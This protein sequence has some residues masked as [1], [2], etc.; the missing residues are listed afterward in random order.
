MDSVVIGA[1]GVQILLATGQDLTEATKLEMHVV[2]PDGSTTTW[3]ATASATP[4]SIEYITQAGDLDL[5]GH[6]FIHSYVEWGSTSKH[7]GTEPYELRVLTPGM[8][9]SCAKIRAIINLKDGT[10]EGDP[11]ELSDEAIEGAISRSETFVSD[12][13]SRSG[14]S[15]DIVALATLDYAA[16]LAYQTYADRIVEE[17]PGSY[18]GGEFTPIANPI[19]KQVLE[20]LRGLKQTSDESLEIIRNTPPEAAQGETPMPSDLEDYP[21]DLKISNLN[22]SW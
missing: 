9:T 7:T 13:A 18:T 6:Y 15:V 4:G 20:K 12:L 21:D 22:T 3:T 17:L 19:G 5:A 1:V 8:A 16:Y 11:I 10:S 14:A 2:K